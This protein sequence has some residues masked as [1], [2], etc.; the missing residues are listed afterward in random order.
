[1]KTGTHKKMITSVVLVYPFTVIDANSIYGVFQGSDGKIRKGDKIEPS[2]G[3]GY[4]AAY[5]KQYYPQVHV[6]VFDANAMA[7]KKCIADNTVNI[8][9]LWNMFRQEI[10]HLAPDFVGISC[11]SLVTAE[12]TRTSASII[13][14]LDPNTYVAIGG[15][16]ANTSYDEALLEGNYIDFVVFGEGEMSSMNLIRALNDG[17]DLITVKGIAYV[18]HKKKIVQTTPQELI[19]DLDSIPK[20]DR[21]T[22]DMDFYSKN[23]NYFIY[24]FLDRDKTRVAPIMASRGCS[25][26]CAFC[27]ARLIWGGKIRYRNPK[28]VVDEM[29]GLRDIDNINTFCFF[30]ANILGDKREFIRLANEIRSRLPDITWMSIEGME[31]AN[32]D[33]EVIHAM[34]DSG[35][36]WFVLPF[37]SG[38]N[39]SLRKIGKR[40]YIDMVDPIIKAIRKIEG[41]WISGNLITGL[42]FET[43]ADIDE[44]IRYATA[45]DLDWLYVYRFIPFPGIAMYKE[46]LDKKYVNKY[47]W[48]SQK[49][50]ELWK[51]ETPNFSSECLAEKNYN[52]NI[53]YN[54]FHNR[55]LKHRPEQ[56][57][58]DFNY[59]L[60]RAEDHAVGMYC[61]GIAYKTLGKYDE[62]E[63]CLL[64][65]I[66]VAD[67]STGNA[68]DKSMVDNGMESISKSF[69]VIGKDIKYAKYFKDGGI[70]LV[71]ELHAIREL[72]ATDLLYAV[73]NIGDH[74][75]PRK[76]DLS[77]P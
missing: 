71:K 46:C 62:A 32:L 33:E 24:R 23:G 3:L 66:A 34:C 9:E 50:H 28:L 25:N 11:F 74:H 12:S 36:K 41:T 42:P 61:M 47:A 69:V 75:N 26:G 64:K 17:A 38:S 54:F 73:Q 35:C 20:C 49:I 31:I 37:E 40:H 63:R 15:N 14:E 19:E 77:R 60:D 4:I 55:N 70:D 18:D 58:R 43:L 48:N 2:L 57:I 22:T 29:V 45:L 16:Y 67:A 59:V 68:D 8:P 53:E 21:S 30:D 5:L 56:A 10:K 1:M 51:L 27:T 72:K 65:A 13:K 76:R 44:S 7:I 52:V 39:E 6:H